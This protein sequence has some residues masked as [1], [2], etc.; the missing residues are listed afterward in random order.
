MTDA[1]LHDS[2]LESFSGI[3]AAFFAFCILFAVEVIEFLVKLLRHYILFYQWRRNMRKLKQ[4]EE[5]EAEAEVKAQ[6]E[7]EKEKIE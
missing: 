1:N 6:T 2:K 5:A 3:L 4:E 7:R